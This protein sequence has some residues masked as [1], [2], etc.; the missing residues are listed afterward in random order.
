MARKQM[1]D[2]VRIQGRNFCTIQAYANLKGVTRQTV[3]N[4]LNSHEKRN[5]LDII[6]VVWMGHTLIQVK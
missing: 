4:W 6:T 1:Q 3:Y 2:Y 5:E